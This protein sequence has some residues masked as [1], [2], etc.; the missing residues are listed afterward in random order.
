[1][2]EVVSNVAWGD[3]EG[4]TLYITGSTSIYRIKL[5]ARGVRN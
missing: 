3:K 1:V 5:S 4:K 2:P